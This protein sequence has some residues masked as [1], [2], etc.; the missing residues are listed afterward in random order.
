MISLDMIKLPSSLS[1]QSLHTLIWRP[2]SPVGVVQILHGMS[3][4]IA[5]YNEFARFLCENGYAVI[6]HS[7]LGHGLTAA[8]ADDLGYFGKSN[9]WNNL[10]N[11]VHTVRLEAQK[12]FGSLPHYILGHSMGSFVTR[13]YI[14]RPEASG[15]AGVIICGT[16]HTPA[17][18]LGTGRIITSL[19]GLFCGRRHRS[20]LVNSLSFG[21]YGKAFSPCRTDFD[22]LSNNSDD[23]DKYIADPLCGFCFT[24]S[25]F[26]D[27]FTGLLYIGKTKNIAKT[28]SSLPCLFISGDRDPVGDC[29]KGVAKVAD[30]FRSAG[31]KDV[32]VQLYEND[33]H[34][35]LN[36]PDRV[37]VYNDILSFLKDAITGLQ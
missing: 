6:G 37:T 24:V 26:R 28:E 32:R 22:W 33:R 25:G 35:V 14:T 10:V 12:Q 19:I 21:G 2:E 18:V 27:M 31:I 34:E 17:A 30:M 8:D 29:G 7:H 11:D 36:E 16:G 5:R 1:G 23:I 13:T 4:H 9:G 3:E 20:K 15:L